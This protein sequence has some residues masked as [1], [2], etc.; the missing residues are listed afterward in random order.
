MH[1]SAE[2]KREIG[3]FSCTM[4]VAG[5]MIGIGIFITAGRIYNT[6]GSPATILLVWLIGGIL[7]LF[8]ALSYAE[9]ATRYPK[10]GGVYIYLKE[11]FGPFMGFLTGF[12]SSLVSIPGT[13]AFLAI[14]FT[15]YAGILDPWAAKSVAVALIALFSVINYWGVK[16]GAKLQDGFM[17]L[18]LVLIFILIL[19]G[20]TV[21]NGSFSNFS[22]TKG[23]P[24]SLWT[25]IP[26]AMIPVM[27]T[28]SG[29]DSTVYVAGEIKNPRVTIPISLFMGTL[30]VALIYMALAVFYIY[31]LPVTSPLNQTRIVTSASAALFGSVAGQVIG[32]LVAV[33]ILGCLAATILTGPRVIYAM[34]KDGLFPS[35]A[36]EIHPVFASP[37]KAILF[38]AVWSSILAMTG[39]FDQL[40]DYVTVPYV[41]F[42][43]LAVLGLMKVRS[44]DKG[45]DENV[46]YLT[47]GYPFVP[48]L[49]ITGTLWIVVNTAVKSPRDSLWGLCIVAL[50]VPIYFVW[51]RWNRAHEIRFP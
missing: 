38:Q 46:P 13:T 20:F 37:S 36:G 29:W 3:V 41:F 6:L 42:T 16:W 10:A 48:V 27:Y 28:Y 49:F 44:K 43:A 5:N 51:K 2:L 18:K 47:W 15:K 9:L 33:S 50:G 7:S 35:A 45:Q 24:I 1:S 26:L 23:L 11:A 21:G 14:G 17:V 30:L 34:A 39:K 31:A 25:A 22:V 19:A 12:S 8:G 32:G 40:L 4:L